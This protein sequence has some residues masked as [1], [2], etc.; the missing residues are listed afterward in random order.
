VRNLAR[1]SQPNRPEQLRVRAG[2]Q[3]GEPVVVAAER[4]ETVLESWLVETCWW[5][6]RPINR[7]YWEVVTRRGR[8]LVVFH[9]LDSGGWFTHAA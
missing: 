6:R 4:V 2:G 3:G 5:T 9:D 1:P 8:R 7:R